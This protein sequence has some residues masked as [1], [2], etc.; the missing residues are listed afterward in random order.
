MAIS[1]SNFDNLVNSALDFYVKEDPLIQN[2]QEKPL[3]AALKERQ[4]TF[5]GGQG[6]I[7][8]PVQGAVA[9]DTAGFFAGYSHT[10]QVGFVHP[11]NIL[12]AKYPWR[13]VHAGI[14]LDYTELKQRGVSIVDG[15]APAA[16]TSGEIQIVKDYVKAVLTNDFGESFARSMNSMC[17][18][19]G[20]Q[21]A[22]QMP[23]VLAVLDDDA[24]SG[25]IGSLD[26]ATYSWWR[27][28]TLVGANAITP[29]AANSTLV[30]TL[31]DE[32]V[33]LMRY[34]GR[35]DLAFAGSDFLSALRE[36]LFGKMQFSQA[37]LSKKDETQ[38]GVADV[39]L[40]NLVFKYDPTLD[41][42]G[43]GKRAY[44]LDSR[45]ITLQPMD[46]QDMVVQ[47]PTR[48]YDQYVLL[49]AV[50]WTGALTFDQLNCHGVY[51][52]K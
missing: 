1:F 19:D 12:R 18:K 17:W 46:G 30:R 39:A 47:K 48:P 20:S 23:G 3:L 10:D 33:Q 7:S 15:K 6:Y 51:E 13:E 34:G 2:I 43:K 49:K 36:E 37:G 16:P 14:V 32:M 25:T 29:S 21:D 22:K 26:R 38:V 45:H 11:D 9:A 27:H 28:R 5:P 8:L 50:T 40:N 4:K 24:T 52:I 31:N 41:Q 35:P 44:I 42:L